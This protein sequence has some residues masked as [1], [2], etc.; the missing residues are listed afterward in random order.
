MEALEQ[1]E[2]AADRGEN[3]VAARV[4]SQVLGTMLPRE[5]FPCRQKSS[6]PCTQVQLRWYTWTIDRLHAPPF[7]HSHALGHMG[8]LE[9]SFG[10]A[11][12]ERE[13]GQDTDLC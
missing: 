1:V 13:C 3:Y 6:P 9:E 4:Q 11:G 10:S 7:A 2:P 8:S 12:S 5:C